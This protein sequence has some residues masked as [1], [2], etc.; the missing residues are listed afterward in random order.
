M[1]SGRRVFLRQTLKGGTLVWLSSLPASVIDV[2]TRWLCVPVRRAVLES[3]TREILRRLND[4]G[5]DEFVLE[6]DAV[7]ITDRLQQILRTKALPLAQAFFAA[8]HPD[9]DS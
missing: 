4:P 5:H 3:R 9:R 2:V 1:I 7:A 6:K 8:L